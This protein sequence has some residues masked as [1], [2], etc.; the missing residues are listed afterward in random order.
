MGE[1]GLSSIMEMFHHN[2][3][4]EHEQPNPNETVICLLNDHI[5]SKQ[6]YENS[7]P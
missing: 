4:T 7:R 5:K 1:G 6:F 2:L 3:E